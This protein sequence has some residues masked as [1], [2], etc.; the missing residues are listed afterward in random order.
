MKKGSTAMEKALLDRGANRKNKAKWA[1]FHYGGCETSWRSW[2]DDPGKMKLAT[3]RAM[4]LSDREMLSI[5]G[6]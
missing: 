4:K 1:A 5:I 3:L 6:S 2:I